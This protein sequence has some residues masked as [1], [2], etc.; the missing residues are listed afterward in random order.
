M[1]CFPLPKRSVS[2]LNHAVPTVLKVSRKARIDFRKVERVFIS[3]YP[4]PP[5]GWGGG[6]FIILTGFA[7]SRTLRP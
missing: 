1:E 4:H 7:F 2:D 6:N 3:V 5:T